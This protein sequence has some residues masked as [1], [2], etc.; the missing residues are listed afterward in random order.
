MEQRGKKDAFD[1]RRLECSTGP[2]VTQFGPV[3]P[4]TLPTWTFV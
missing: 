2:V 1:A 4:G 3:I